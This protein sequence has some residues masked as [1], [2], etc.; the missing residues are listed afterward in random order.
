M[1]KKP[2]I[3]LVIL[4]NPITSIVAM[5]IGVFLGFTN[6]DFS[7]ALAPYGEAYQLLLKMTVLPVLLSAIITSL[8]RFISIHS[9]RKLIGKIVI[10]LVLVSVIYSAVGIIVGVVF[11]PGNL[12]EENRNIISE[13]V[14]LQSEILEIELEVQQEEEDSKIFDF[15]LYVFPENIFNSL[16]NNRVLSVLI[17]SVFFGLAIGAVPKKHDSSTLI[18]LLFEEIYITFSNIIR[19]IMLLLPIALICIISSEIARSGFDIILSSSKLISQFYI[20]GIVLLVINTVV[21][22]VSSKKGLLKSFHAISYPSIVAFTTRN[23]IASM[24]IAINTLNKRFDVNYNFAKITMPLLIVLGRFG[25]IFY[26]ALAAIFSTQIYFI[27]LNVESI[28]F[29]C[30]I[31]VVAGLATAGASGFVTLGLLGIVMEPLGIPFDTILVILLIIDVIVDP[32]RTTLIVH[33]NTVL[34]EILH[35]MF[36]KNK[37]AQKK[38]ISEAFDPV[39]T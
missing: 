21:L 18:I 4:K 28:I 20:F 39:H 36:L 3:I 19:Y 5:G 27:E 24:T 38:H 2:S 1:N 37:A 32:L 22:S 11:K 33:T 25:N 9:M 8:G 31:V 16:A 30:F 15:L 7:L 6:K 14:S 29:L 10:L 13:Q 26:F 23:S 34:T 12:S 35:G 17:F